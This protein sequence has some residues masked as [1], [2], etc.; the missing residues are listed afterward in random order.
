MAEAGGGGSVPGVI[1]DFVI[2][3]IKNV[4]SPGPRRPT[5]EDAAILRDRGW[6]MGTNRSSGFVPG[7]ILPGKGAIQAVW[8]DAAGNQYSQDAARRAAEAYRAQWEQVPPIPPGHD[9][10]TP[11]L[12]PGLPLP[13]IPP[14]IA[15]AVRA[16]PWPVLGGPIG[17]GVLMWPTA[18][19]TGA[20]LRDLYAIPKPATPGGRRGRGRRR[21][22]RAR[23]RAAPG[24]GNPFP[25]A[26][27]GRGGPV[28]IRT[29]PG[30]A[31]P[32]A[33]RVVSPAWKPSRASLPPV[34]IPKQVIK[35][36]A[37]AR[38]PMT[39]TQ[40]AVAKAK[41]VMTSPLFKYATNIL[42]SPLFNLFQPK[43]TAATVQAP[44]LGQ[45]SLGQ[46]VLPGVSNQP[47]L[48][49]NPLTATNLAG[50]QYSR[51]LALNPAA[52]G[53]QDCSCRPMRKKRKGK[54]CK[55]PVTSRKSFKR[56]GSKFVTTTKEIKCQASSRKKPRLRPVP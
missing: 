49:L 20:D 34:K 22:A 32:P 53:E 13:S 18:A 23:P 4:F 50:L 43:A 12:I 10:S 54:P 40:T 28:T 45:P 41:A 24:R 8:Q 25:P 42:N 14:F 37:P 31:V 1:V 46:I 6:E 44:S 33:V 38:V 27:P 16:L 5:A 21:R 47:G 35:A 9:A 15:G 30:V 56:N 2:G 51:A 11:P 36:P 26:A 48:N 7:L 3:G 29:R 39:R 19:G 17:A 55:N 52:V